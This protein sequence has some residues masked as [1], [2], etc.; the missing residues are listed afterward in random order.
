MADQRTFLD[1][2]LGIFVSQLLAL[3]EHADGDFVTPLKRLVQS[4]IIIFRVVALLVLELVYLL[5]EKL[6]GVDL[7]AGD[8]RAEYIHE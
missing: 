5:P 3:I 1:G 8:A 6:V 7:V 4:G 2:G